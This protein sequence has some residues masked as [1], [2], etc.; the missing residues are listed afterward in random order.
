MSA[1]SDELLLSVHDLRIDFHTRQGVFTAVHGISFEMH[2]G[3]LLG[4]VGELGSGKSVTAL[5]LLRLLP[6]HSAQVSSGA[7]LFDGVD[8]GGFTERQMQ[9]VRGQKIGM[10]FQDPMTSLNPIFTIGRQLRQPLQLHLGLSRNMADKRAEEL[11]SLVRIP[12]P[13]ECLGRYPHELSGGMRQRVMIAIALACNPMLLIADEP[14]TAL[15]VTTQAQ[16]LDLLRDLQ[17][18]LGMAIMF[19]THDLG[20]VAEFAADVQVMYAGRIVE[21]A[22][23]AELF[24]RPRHPYTE[25]LLG[26]MPPFEGEDPERL[27]AIDGAVPSPFAPPSGCAFHPRCPHAFADC[28]TV[29]PT[30]ARLSERH[31]AACLRNV[32]S[33]A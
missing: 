3:Q 20:I 31:E 28:T 7:M 30:L 5:S 17:R 14:T 6:D 32:A 15:D 25:G 23:V 12:S 10:I 13:R 1:P 22:P 16:I 21:R 19:I 4:V 33:Y 18:D 9:A 24:E 8:L 11:L 26:S 27:S 29:V 2:R